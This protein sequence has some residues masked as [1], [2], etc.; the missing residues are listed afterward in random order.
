[1]SAPLSRKG[2]RTLFIEFLIIVIGVFIAL[3]A[4][5]W[6]SE[7]EDRLRESD[8][9]EDIVAEFAANIR[10]LEADIAVN[11]GMRTMYQAGLLKCLQGVTTVEEVLRVT[12]DA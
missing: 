2:A 8:I 11:E 12:Q 3:A 9:R 4:E 7:R 6:W 5:S 10:I 1:M